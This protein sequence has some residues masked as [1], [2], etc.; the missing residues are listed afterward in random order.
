MKVQLGSQQ[1]YPLDAVN[2][3][4]DVLESQPLAGGNLR[5]V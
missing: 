2:A 5:P 3:V 4:V 1:P